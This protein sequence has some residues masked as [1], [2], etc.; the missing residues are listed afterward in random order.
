[1]K[2]FI[3][4]LSYSKLQTLMFEL[5]VRDSYKASDSVLSFVKAKLTQSSSPPKNPCLLCWLASPSQVLADTHGI[6]KDENLK[7]L[8]CDFVI[9][10]LNR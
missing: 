7:E 8:C 5:L 3:A 4:V 6:V 2:S 10:F 1:M 9:N